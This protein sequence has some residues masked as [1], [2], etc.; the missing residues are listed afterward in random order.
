M[1]GR[2]LAPFEADILDELL[3]AQ[4]Q[5]SVAPIS[6]VAHGR[7]T[8]R[9]VAVTLT[10]AAAVGGATSVAV[11]A[12]HSTPSTPR[13]ESPTTQTATGGPPETPLATL[14]VAL[15]ARR[16]EMNLA[17]VDNL[18]VQGRE[19]RI[20]AT[21]SGT[22]IQVFEFWWD[23]GDP[24]HS[25]TKYTHNGVPVYDIQKDDGRASERFVDYQTR[26]W[27]QSG[28]VPS[29][30]GHG[31][32]LGWNPDFVRK[33][34]RVKGLTLVGHETIDGRDTLHLARHDIAP[35]PGDLWIDPTT[36]LIVR[37]GGPLG[38]TDYQWLPRNA[39]SLA[40]L[41]PVVP[42]GFTFRGQ[43]PQTP[44]GADANKG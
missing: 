30:K 8:R 2:T 37:S 12:N 38:T 6:Y 33:L 25:R 14:T 31:Q 42:L 32:L 18:I 9:R 26:S 3:D 4:R 10:V 35:M 23:R 36:Y 7:S 13:A 27:Y 1:T 28:P 40:Q 39:A 20:S 34:L 5:L 17:N 44:P 22:D 16:A 11:V 41:V 29:M 15:I 43:A 24:M 19:T 21:P